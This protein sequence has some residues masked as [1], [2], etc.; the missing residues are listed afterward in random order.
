MY[1]CIFPSTYLS[2]HTLVVQVLW[3]TLTD[4]PVNT[5]QAG[6]REMTSLS[7]ILH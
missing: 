2:I 4:T 6:G 7:T 1:L 5:V 3:R